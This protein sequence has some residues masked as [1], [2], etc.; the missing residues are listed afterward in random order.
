VDPTLTELKVNNLI[1]IMSDGSQPED[2]YQASNGHHMAE[3]P[4]IMVTHHVLYNPDP[5]PESCDLAI[6]H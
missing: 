4:K 3:D 5:E 6:K 1:T 2:A